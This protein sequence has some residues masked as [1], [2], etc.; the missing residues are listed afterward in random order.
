[1]KV[2]E[3]W[4]ALFQEVARSQTCLCDQKQQKYCFF[5]SI[6][7]T[8]YTQCLKGMKICVFQ[9]PVTSFSFFKL[10][11]LA[12]YCVYLRKAFSLNLFQRRQQS[13]KFIFRHTAKLKEYVHHPDSTVSFFC[14]SLPYP[15]I[16]SFSFFMFSEANYSFHPHFAKCFNICVINQSSVFK[17]SSLDIKFI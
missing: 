10:C 16:K 13:F 6:V 1:M 8:N 11:L 15:S 3:D 5:K 12:T 14:Y 9:S 4:H 7:K 17:I 2:R